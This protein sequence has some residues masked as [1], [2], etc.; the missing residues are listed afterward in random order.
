M[1]PIYRQCHNCARVYNTGI[2]VGSAL[3]L[4]NMSRCPNCGRVGPIDDAYYQVSTKSGAVVATYGQHQVLLDL[5]EELRD[6]HSQADLDSVRHDSRF[7]A[8]EKWLPKNYGHIVATII[9]IIEILRFN[10]SSEPNIEVRMYE[11][12][13]HI[14]KVEQVYNIQFRESVEDIEEE[15]HGNKSE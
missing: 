9:L 8:F 13:Q 3:L 4:G 12:N 6:V 14:I 11:L 7:A 2:S 10:A 5:L 1:P 15:N